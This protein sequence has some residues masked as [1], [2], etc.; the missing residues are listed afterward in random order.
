MVTRTDGE[1]WIVLVADDRRY[2]VKPHATF[3]WEESLCSRMVSG[4]L[5]RMAPRLSS[6]GIGRLTP[7][8]AYAGVPL[9]YRDGEL[10]GTLCAIDPKPQPES[11]VQQLP[12]MEMVAGMLSGV[13]AA[14]W[15]AVEAGREKERL[16][17]EGETD[18][19]T[20]MFNSR[21]WDRLIGIEGARCRRYGNSACVVLVDLDGL[22][23][24][25]D[26]RG[27]AVGDRLIRRAARVLLRSVRCSDLVARLGGDK[28]G[29]L[30]VQCNPREADLLAQRI[31]KELERAGVSASV[32]MSSRVPAIQLGEVWR[33]ADDFMLDEKIS[34]K[35]RKSAGDMRKFSRSRV[36]PPRPL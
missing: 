36:F 6:A 25:N 32:G 24:V 29:V 5:P 2:G 22:K 26:A 16:A 28:F 21:G 12:L 3:R 4:S 18:F 11:I 27:A 13:L 10:F 20:G 9:R 19:L 1:A 30:G 17:A 35:L 14:E 31:R 7:I 23:T 8:G 15:V 34:R 33:E